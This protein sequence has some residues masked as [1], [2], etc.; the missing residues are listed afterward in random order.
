M[1]NQSSTTGY[2]SYLRQNQTIIRVDEKGNAI[3][4]IDK[5]EAHK[6]GILHKGFSVALC[7]GNNIILQL[8]KHPVFDKVVDVTA[9]SHPLVI[10]GKNQ[11]EEN[12]VYDC[13]LREWNVPKNNV[14]NFTNCGS[15]VYKAP[16]NAGYI[17]HEYCTFYS[18]KVE[19]EI[20]PNMEFAYG[21]VTMPLEELKSNPG[22]IPNL[23]PWVREGMKLLR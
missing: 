9:S 10:S 12:A 22:I 8:R 20:K 3:G 17:E 13:L 21:F 11:P 19:K 14:I 1:T 16:D 15:F 18:A 5:W 23:A 6:K 4:S 7:S 2:S